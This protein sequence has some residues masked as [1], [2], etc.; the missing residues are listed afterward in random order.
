MSAPL[1]RLFS[2]ATMLGLFTL[3]FLGTAGALLFL[4]GPRSPLPGIGVAAMAVLGLLAIKGVM[5]RARDTELAL[6]EGERYI[7]TVADLSQDIHA[8]IEARSR[9]FLYLNPAVSNLL[10]YSQEEFIKGG[11][12]FFTSLVHPEDLPILRRQYERLLA[13]V[14]VS[15]REKVQEQ[16]FRLRDHRGAY[17]WFKNRMIVFVR[18][19]SGK[20]AEFLAVIHDV[21]EQ[22]SHEAALLQARKQDSMGALARGILHDLNNTLMG[23]QGFAEIAL[24]GPGDPAQ[25]RRNLEHIQSG[26]ARASSLCRQ[27]VTYTGSGRLQIAP[28]QLNDAIRESMAAIEG[29]VPQG[30]QLELDLEEGLPRVNVDLNQLHYALLNL[31]Y[32]AAEAIRVP[33]GGISISTRARPAQG[34]DGAQVWLEVRDTGPGTAPEIAGQVYDP[35]FP[36]NHPGHGLGLSAVQGIM[37]E[38]SGGVQFLPVPGRGDTTRLTFPLAAV[39]PELEPEEG[40]AL[41]AGQTGV[42]LL[43]DDEPAVR[44]VLRQ[45]LERAGFQVLEAGDGVEGLGAFTRHRAAISLV[46]MDLTMPRMGG[47]EVFAEIH[48]LAPEVPVVLMSGYGEHEATSALAHH[49]LAGFL[50]KPCSIR[51]ALAAVRKALEESVRQAVPPS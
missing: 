13:P 38:H 3:A 22:R 1:K 47:E 11:L 27:M 30:G 9:S 49:G 25:V 20:P 37:R 7:E 43:V 12:V 29:M 35:L 2:T 6:E 39:A 51:D 8:I 34:P 24:D 5:T 33:G 50:S 4:P 10:G 41:E 44:A 42:I 46:L 19:P 31:V 16:T 36:A 17:R 48:R 40:D 21:T 14:P 45:G 32:N 28:R 15:G 26:M 18:R 23:I